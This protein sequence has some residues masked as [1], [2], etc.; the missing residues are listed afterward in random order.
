MV[1]AAGWPNLSPFALIE[2][3]KTDGVPQEREMA[4]A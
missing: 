3:S 2:P 1:A 4:A